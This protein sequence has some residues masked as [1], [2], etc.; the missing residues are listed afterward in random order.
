M[1]MFIVAKLLIAFSQSFSSSL[2]LVSYLIGNL[3]TKQHREKKRY[4]HGM[5]LGLFTLAI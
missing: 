2:Y 4:T 5:A 3:L 1:Y